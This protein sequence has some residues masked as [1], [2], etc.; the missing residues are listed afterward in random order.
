MVLNTKVAKRSVGLGLQRDAMNELATLRIAINPFTPLQSIDFRMLFEDHELEP[1]QA[2]AVSDDFVLTNP[3][4]SSGAFETTKTPT[5][6][7]LFCWRES[8]VEAL[9]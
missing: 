4:Q 1:G 5:W 2:L 7:V 9:Q 3:S 6:H 8:H